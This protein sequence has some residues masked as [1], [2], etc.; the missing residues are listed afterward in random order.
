MCV[1]RRSLGTRGNLWYGIHMRLSLI[2]VLL[3]F[4]TV[5]SFADTFVPPPEFSACASIDIALSGRG[6]L[7]F[8]DIVKDGSAHLAKASM[9]DGHC[10]AGTFKFRDVYENL[11]NHIE[12]KNKVYPYQYEV[13]FYP[14]NSHYVFPNGYLNDEKIIRDL[15]VTFKA[16]GSLGSKDD[17]EKLFPGSPSRQSK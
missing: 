3:G 2:L 4:S 7:Y 12:R 17:F 14:A 6:A 5:A 8:L 13:C 15:L 1:P 11:S 16:R 9:L 10:P